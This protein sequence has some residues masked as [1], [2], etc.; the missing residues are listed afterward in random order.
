MQL[1]FGTNSIIFALVGLFLA[2]GHWMGAVIGF[3]IGSYVDRMKVVAQKSRNEYRKTGNQSS[4]EDFVRQQFQRR[5]YSPSQFSSA[6]LIL[7]AEVMKADGKVLKSELDFVKK[8][9]V[10]Q[11]GRD[12][13]PKYLQELRGYLNQSSN[14]EQT[15]ASFRNFIPPQQK[16]ILIQYLFGIAQ[17]D[18]NVSNTEL[19][20]IQRIAGLLG[21]RQYEFDQLKSMFWKDSADAYKTLGLNKSASDSEIKT[22]YRKLAR[23]HHPDKVA[24]LGEQ[25]QKAAKEKFQKIQEAYETIKKERGL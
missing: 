2:R 19:N 9:L 5:Q 1:I 7:S 17:S 14:L 6:L 4:Y 18:G 13:A 3:L 8:F 21:L 23:E 22:A 15:C 16:Q 20:V 10:Q 12:Y 11:F 25:Y 24:S